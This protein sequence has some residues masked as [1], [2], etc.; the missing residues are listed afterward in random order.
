M[1]SKFKVGDQVKYGKSI[2]YISSIFQFGGSETEGPEIRASLNDKNGLAFTSIS[3][4]DLE[5]TDDENDKVKKQENKLLNNN[6]GND[7]IQVFGGAQQ[8]F[9]RNDKVFTND[10]KFKTGE[11][12]KCIKG[13]GN[14]KIGDMCIV[15][16]FKNSD[17]TYTKGV[18]SPM[19]LSLG[20]GIPVAYDLID[21]LD[22]F[23]LVDDEKNSDYENEIENQIKRL[24][25]MLAATVKLLEEEKGELVST[26]SIVMKAIELF[27]NNI[28]NDK[29]KKPESTLKPEHHRLDLNFINEL[30]LHM[31]KAAHIKYP[32]INGEPNWKCHNPKNTNELIDAAIRHI[33]QF[34]M[35]N[36]FDLEFGTHHLISA[37]ANLMMCYFY[38]N[39]VNSKKE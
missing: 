35:G 8:I 5:L 37:A 14:I 26:N 31:T 29:V 33:Y 39:K 13:L 15:H 12:I 7:K 30:A 1:K 22:Y 4:K 23:E 38:I 9:I 17:G 24:Q 28:E 3:L 6:V 25:V 16:N 10:S 18:L 19:D 11:M 32:D 20:Q 34:G 2:Y 21:Y 27:N 36:E